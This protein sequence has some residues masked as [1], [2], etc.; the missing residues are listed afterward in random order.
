M[1]TPAIGMAALGIGPG[2]PQLVTLRAVAMFEAADVILVPAAEAS[3]REAGHA[4]AGGH[5]ERPHRTVP[6]ARSCL[7]RPLPEA[8][9][10]DRIPVG[11][12]GAAESTSAGA[13]N[14]CG[15]ECIVVLGCRRQSRHRGSSTRA[16]RHGR[17][18]RWLKNSPTHTEGGRDQDDR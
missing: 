3:D 15:V 14:D 16:V 11:F 8:R 5:V 18:H 6:R 13:Q 7:A 17:A 12:I 9:G 10:G 1:A 4:T 2:D